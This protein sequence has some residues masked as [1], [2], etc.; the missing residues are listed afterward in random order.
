MDVLLRLDAVPG[1]DP[2]VQE[3]RHAI[4]RYVVSLQEVFDSMFAAPEADTDEIWGVGEASYVPPPAASAEE[5]RR[6]GWGIGEAATA[7]SNVQQ[8]RRR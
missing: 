4:S 7:T 6:S 2:A 5:A 8:R 1:H 3:V